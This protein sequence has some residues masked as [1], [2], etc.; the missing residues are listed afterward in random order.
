MNKIFILFFLMPFSLFSQIKDNW[1]HFDPERDS[2]LGISTYRAYEFLKGKASETVTV[3]VLD[4]GAALTH[5][6]L[7][8]QYWINDGE[9]PDNGIDDDKNGYVDDIHGWNFLG[10]S[11]GENIKRETTE[12][13]RIYARLKGK[14]EGKEIS[15]LTKVDSVKCA[16]FQEIN[17]DFE[18][19]IKNKKDD[20]KFYKI[21][22][23]KYIWSN[24]RLTEYFGHADYNKDSILKIDSN[25][26]IIN[27]AKDFTLWM[28]D[29]SFDDKAL[30]SAI[31]NMEEDL[32]TRLNPSFDVRKKIIG[33]DPSNLADSIYGNNQVDAMG[34]YHGTGVAGT[35]GAL[36]NNTGVNGIAKNVKLMILRVLP[37]G[38]ERDKDIALAI[39]YAVRNG[40]DIINC[41]FGKQYSSYPEFVQQAIEEAEK[42]GVLIVHAA[43]ND[44]KNNDSIPTYPTGFYENG[45]RAENWISVGAT[46]LKDDKKLLAPFS[47]YGKK[48]VD[49]F[50]PGVDIMS[51]VLGNK[52]ELASGTSTAA[53]VVAGIAAVLKS[54]Y[55]ELNAKQ[56]KEIIVQSAYK[57]K[58]NSVYLPGTKKLMNFSDLSVSEGI[59]NLYNAV[60]LAEKLYPRKK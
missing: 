22:L 28:M 45:E 13:T 40:A 47:N 31:K 51:C 32:K 46:G 4:N 30:E 52:Y 42:A 26:T 37:N 55:P 11:K 50:A 3:A 43:G 33:D 36:W 1:Q 14:Y 9:I 12:L 24:V 57:P 48:T 59:A 53:P 5:E 54:Y 21:L 20:I 10:N 18:R 38:D 25:S 29:V 15:L 6:D 17:E 19:G 16:H 56:L 39:R 8:G 35:I 2:L 34:P 58:T 27:G 23:Q 44:S 49:V 60:L 41:S 7:Q